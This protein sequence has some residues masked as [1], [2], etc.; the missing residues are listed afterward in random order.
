MG[1][2]YGIKYTDYFIKQWQKL[3]DKSKRLIEGKLSLI[4]GNPFRYPNHKGYR[5]VFK[6]KLSIQNT[7][8]RLMYAVYAPNKNSIT[9]LGIFP[10]ERGYKDFKHLFGY[11][12]D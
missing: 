1:S 9:I 10:R 3:D 5:R 12:K 6:V 8:S 2:G 11:L 4:V 7:Y